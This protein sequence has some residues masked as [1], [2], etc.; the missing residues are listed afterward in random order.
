MNQKKKCKELKRIS[1]ENLNGKYKP[2]MAAFLLV[3]LINLLTDMPFTYLLG[4]VYATTVQTVI[5][6]IAEVLLSI[7]VGVLNMGL[8]R[9]HL[10]MAKK[11]QIRLT[12]VFYCFRNR[13]NRYFGAY[14]IYYIISM[15]AKTP[16]LV[17]R[18]F[19]KFKGDTL[20]TAIGLTAVS[21]VLSIIVFVLLAFYMYLIISREDFGVF[22]CLAQSIKL[23]L[24]NI[25]RL[26]Y[27]YLSFVGMLVLCL[28]SLGIGFL[29]VEPYFQQTM[30]NFYLDVTGELPRVDY[31]V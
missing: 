7:V 6:Y 12:D 4:N 23:I 18:T 21:V 27:I 13:S 9:F 3:I 17:A 11:Q 5:Y 29:W 15:I 24:G 22:A 1:R 30:A 10:N 8:I 16:Y 20:Y 14:I 2:A 26:I 28:L 25:H 31:T 19:F